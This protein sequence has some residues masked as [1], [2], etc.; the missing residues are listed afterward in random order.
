MSQVFEDM[1]NTFRNSQ[2]ALA[3]AVTFKLNSTSSAKTV[4]TNLFYEDVEVR[5]GEM[6]STVK[7]LMGLF[8]SDAVAGADHDSYI[9]R[10]GVTFYLIKRAL[11][12]DGETAI[13]FSKN[14]IT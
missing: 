4:Y 9:I 8:N 12:D 5:S 10:N 6:N 14:K 2:C 11:D 3:E 13:W 7:A 1:N